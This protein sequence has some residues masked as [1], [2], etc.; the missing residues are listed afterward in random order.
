MK[1]LKTIGISVLI[2]GAC[3][4]LIVRPTNADT[5][6][7]TSAPTH[8]VWMGAYGIFE[9]KKFGQYC[10]PGNIITKVPQ[11]EAVSVRETKS[12]EGVP[13]DFKRVSYQQYSGWMW[14]FTLQELDPE[15]V[16]IL[17]EQ[18]PVIKEEIEE[19]A[20]IEEEHYGYN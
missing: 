13:H 4:F 2:A 19:E 9:L 15:E 12:C 10:M 1:I 7:N 8:K 16:A 14:D 20:E 5:G 6:T 3:A 17:M 18:V 11:G